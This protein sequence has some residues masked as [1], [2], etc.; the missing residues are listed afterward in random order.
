MNDAETIEFLSLLRSIDDHLMEMN[1][2]MDDIVSWK[3]D[4]DT[5]LDHSETSIAKLS[6]I[7]DS[8]Q[9]QIGEAAQMKDALSWIASAIRSLH[10]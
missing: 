9:E 1:N 3:E 5:L 8:L 10:Q 2:K 4:V 6:E 7:C